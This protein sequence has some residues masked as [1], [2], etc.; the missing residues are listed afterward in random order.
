MDIRCCTR[1][2]FR[3]ENVSLSKEWLS[4]SK[5]KGLEW[6]YRITPELITQTGVGGYRLPTEAEWEFACRAGTTTLYYSGNDPGELS[7]FAWFADAGGK[8]T[9]PV[10]QKS[11]KAFGLYDMHGNVYEWVHDVWRPD[12]YSTL[13]QANAIDPRCDTGPEPRR[14]IRGGNYGLNAEECRSAGRDVKGARWDFVVTDGEE[15][16]AKGYF[17]VQDKVI[18]KGKKK[19]GRLEAESRTETQPLIC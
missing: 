14:V 5:E 3:S 18:Y 7:R 11:P 17:R 9:Q 15:T 10:A 13:T 2:K 4:E 12:W 19:V 1:H 6:A 16:I 8:T